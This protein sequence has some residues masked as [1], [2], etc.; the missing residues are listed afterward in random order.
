MDSVTNTTTMYN[1]SRNEFDKDV[2]LPD[3]LYEHNV[4]NVNSTHMVVIGAGNM[5]SDL[6]WIYDRLVS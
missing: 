6:A 3:D 2:Y 1:Q 5:E 4:V